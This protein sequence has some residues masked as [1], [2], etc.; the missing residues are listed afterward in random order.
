M[1]GFPQPGDRYGDFRI[2]EVLGVGA[3]ALV[4]KV[5]SPLHDEPM[6]LKLS[7]EPVISEAVALRA[8]REIRILTGLSSPH[9][10]KI[11]D[12]GLGPDERWFMV[13]ELLRGQDLSTAHDLDHPMDFLDAVRVIYE[14]CLGLEEAHRAGIVHRDIKP[15]NLWVTPSGSI[16]VLDF[17]LARSW[18]GDSI[19]AANATSGHVLVGTP[20]YAQPEQV[21]TGKLTPASDVYSL[22]FL[23][24]ELLTGRTPLFADRS[25]SKVRT[26]LA[27]EPLQWLSAHVK[28][29]VVPL[30][31]YPEGQ[32]LPEDLRTLIHRALDKDP[33]QRPVTAGE[34]ANRLAWMLPPRLGGWCG[35]AGWVLEHEDA[36]GYT[37]R[38]LLPR[39]V[40][41]I[42]IG[43]CCDVRLADDHVGWVYAQLEWQASEL[44]V[45]HPVRRDGFITLGSVPVQAS[46][47]LSPPL[48][49][50]FGAH[51]L[52]ITG[53]NEPA[54]VTA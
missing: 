5:R 23:L 50:R 43:P 46:T 32:R 44:P 54:N 25:C 17:G 33:A 39:G 2:L 42:G 3:F 52:R 19:V 27:N 49:L 18:G 48:E 29:A 12:H 37:R 36:P 16:K 14:A 6:A 40:H 15:R 24:Y 13:M 51:V 8:L 45:L 53:Y 9:V 10:V 4:Y 11:Y 31:H 26:R 1:Q 7:K 30:E 22:A 35:A 34:F 38:V 28:S 47:V 41:R 21:K 20:H